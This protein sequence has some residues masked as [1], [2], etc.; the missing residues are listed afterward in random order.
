M[1]IYTYITF[2]FILMLAITDAQSAKAGQT[3]EQQMVKLSSKEAICITQNKEKYFE[4]TRV[5]IQVIP[6]SCPLT[7]LSAV[8]KLGQNSQSASEERIYW[9]S[10]EQ[11]ECL[12][13]NI[14]KSLPQLSASKENKIPQQLTF[15]MD[16][17]K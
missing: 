12:I 17:L 14:E 2:L 7:G 5:L 8:E 3:E 13:T 16:C 11:L 1:K 9:L 15:P 6:V 4:T 10:R